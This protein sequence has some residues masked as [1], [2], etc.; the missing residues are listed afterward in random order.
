MKLHYSLPALAKQ[1]WAPLDMPGVTNHTKLVG[2]Q[3][4]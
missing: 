3:F 1:L 2:L 4:E